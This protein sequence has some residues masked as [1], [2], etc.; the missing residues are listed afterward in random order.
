MCFQKKSQSSFAIFWFLIWIRHLPLEG[1]WVKYW[2]IKCCL[3]ILYNTRAWE[4]GRKQVTSTQTCVLKWGRDA[5]RYCSLFNWSLVPSSFTTCPCALCPQEAHQAVTM[6][7]F[8]TLPKAS[9]HWLYS[10]G[11]APTSVAGYGR[12]Q[13]SLYCAEATTSGLSLAN[14]HQNSVIP[15]HGD[16]RPPVAPR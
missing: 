7:C 9:V 4:K 8:S 12:S 10:C 16:E 15:I 14:Q 1:L 6:P 13:R 3:H 2:N 5:S 11:F